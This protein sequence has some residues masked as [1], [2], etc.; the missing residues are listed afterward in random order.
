MNKNRN[1]VYILEKHHGMGKLGEK[2]VPCRIID[3]RNSEVI[4]ELEDIPLGEVHTKYLNNLVYEKEIIKDKL[5]NLILD[6]DEI[7]DMNYWMGLSES[8]E[9]MQ[10]MVEDLFKDPEG[11]TIQHDAEE[12]KCYDKEEGECL[13]FNKE[14]EPEDVCFCND[15]VWGDRF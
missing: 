6:Y 8:V 13:K 12:C 4:L 15:F 10:D 9:S 1:E 2:Y 5:L 7:S 11:F 3:T 14:L